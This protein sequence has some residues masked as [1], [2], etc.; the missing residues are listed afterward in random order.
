MNPT[1]QLLEPEIR[2]LVRDGLYSELREALHLLPHADV[3]EILAAMPSNDAAV[4]FRFMPRDDAAEAFAYLLPED[5]EDIIAALGNEAAVRVVE[6]MSADDRARLLDELPEGVAHRIVGSLSPEARKTTQAILG[7]PARSVG[8]LMTPDYIAVRPDWNIAQ[9]VDHIRRVGRDA[10]TVNVVYVVD[11]Q[12]KLIDDLRLRQIIFADPNA[13]VESIMNRQFVTLRAEQDQSEAVA[14]LTHYDRVALPVIDSRGVLLGIVTHDDV[15][16]VAQAEVTEDM[17][18]MGGLEALDE[19][20]T[21]IPFTRLVR[22]RVSWLAA[23][24]IGEMFT[25]SALGYFEDELERT[26]V[27]SLFIPLIVSSGGNSGSQASSLII[28][29]MALREISVRDWWKVLR[30]EI[31]CGAA[32]GLILGIMG[33]IRIHFWQWTGMA[34][35][36]V[37]YHLVGL[38]VMCALLG[39]VLWGSIVG[40]MLPF[41]LKKFK[42]DPA[43]SSAPFVATLVDVTGIV[44]YL[45]VAMAILHSTLL[46][47][48]KFTE[49]PIPGGTAEAIVDSVMEDPQGD[50]FVFVEVQ[51]PE[52]KAK[53]EG[54]RVKVPLTGLPDGKKPVEGQRVLLHLQADKAASIEYIK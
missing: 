32:L 50:P 44:I 38:T 8:R 19:P 37:H 48:A 22:K 28:R 2:E 42:L 26:V 4:A 9:A 49:Q 15:A 30:R 40:A 39:I 47:P 25:A 29:A 21:T 6:A 54:T 41:I 7:Y 12:G 16:D 24:F 52:Q 46:A 35:Y 3:A 1:A 45:T 20:Y 23:L 33:L 18:K 31:A 53:N 17:Q 27:L 10:E 34:N 14:A 36:T 5:Q 51:T 11:E 43:T 13:T